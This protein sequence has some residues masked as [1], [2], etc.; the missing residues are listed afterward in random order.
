MELQNDGGNEGGA[1]GR[2]CGL[3]LWVLIGAQAMLTIYT[4]MGM[5]WRWV[6][7]DLES[8]VAAIGQIIERISNSWS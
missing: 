8:A 1:I 7:P 5:L 4:V 3:A 6:E 2:G